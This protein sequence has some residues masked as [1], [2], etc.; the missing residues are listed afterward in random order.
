[1]IRIKKQE[2]TGV[3][4]DTNVLIIANNDPQHVDPSKFNQELHTSCNERLIEAIKSQ[5]GQLLILLDVEGEIIKEY[6]SY[7]SFAG[8]PGLGDYFFKWLIDHEYNSKINICRTQTK[9]G[10]FE[11]FKKHT[12]FSKL[13]KGDIKFLNPTLS[14]ISSKPNAVARIIFAADF[15]DWELA[16]EVFKSEEKLIFESLSS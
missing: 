4:F 6:K 7:A 10:L 1:M 15:K 3:C 9:E 13:D 11:P 16:S 14:Y 2:K 8:N 5:S 12:K